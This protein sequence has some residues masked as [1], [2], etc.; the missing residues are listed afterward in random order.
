MGTFKKF[1]RETQ[2]WEV[3]STSDASVIGIRSEKLLPDGVSETNVEEV[4]MRM[5]DSIDTLK[6]NVSWLA[7]YG[8]S[9]GGS[10]SAL[11]GAITVNDQPTGTT[12][13]LDKSLVINIQASIAG[14][15]W[16]ISV[17]ANNKVI[18]SSIGTKLEL[19]KQDLLDAGLNTT[20]RLSISALNQDSMASLYWNGEIQITSIDLTTSNVNY[21]FQDRNSKVQLID[22]QVSV[23]G[24]YY[25]TINEEEVWRDN[26]VKNAG[27]I[28]IPLKILDE[29]GLLQVGNNTLQI[30]LHI[31]EEVYGETYAQVVLT[32]ETPIIVSNSLSETQINEIPINLGQINIIRMSYIVYYQAGN[33]KTKI[34]KKG[35]VTNFQD[36]YNSYNVLYDNASYALYSEEYGEQI[37][38]IIEIQDS[39]TQKSYYKEYNLVTVEPKQGLLSQ[40]LDSVFDFITYNGYINNGVWNQG[41][42]NLEIHNINYYSQSI[43]TDTK[44]LRLQNASYGTININKQ[45]LATSNVLEFTLL[46]CYEAD[47]H[48][49]DDRTILQFGNIGMDQQPINGIFVKAH[50][51][52]VGA[53]TVDLQDRE[54]INLAITYKQIPN[55]EWGQAFV[56]IDAVLEASFTVQAQMICPTQNNITIY[57][58]AQEQ[59]NAFTDVTIYRISL[60]KK[61]LNPYQLLLEFLNNQARTHLLTS[62]LP[63]ASYIDDGLLRNFIHRNEKGDLIPLL[64]NTSYN[65][66]VNADDFSDAFTLEN[67]IS[68]SDNSIEFRSDISNYRIPIP[69]M[70]LD[71]SSAWSWNNFITP[72]AEL[73]PLGGCALRYYDQ[74]Q[75]SSKIIQAS[76]DVSLQ[77][78]STLA[79]Y[80]KNIN[81]SFDDNCVF[82]PKPHWLPEKTYTL[83]ADIVDSSHSLNPSIGKFVNDEFGMAYDENGQVSSASSWYPF[84]ESV[85]DS[86][87]QAKQT[88]YMQDYFPQATLKHGVEGYPIFLIMRFQNGVDSKGKPLYKIA[89]LGIYQFILG[90]NSSRNLGYDIIDSVKGMDVNP[91]YPYFKAGVDIV[92][93]QNPGYWIEAVQNDSFSDTLGFQELNSIQDAQLTGVFWQKDITYLNNSF[94]I[95]FTNLGSNAVSKPADFNEFMNFVDSIIKLPVTNRRYSQEGNNIL[96]RNTFTNQTYPKYELQQING[97][98]KWIKTNQVNTIV[99]RGDELNSVLQKLNIESISRFYV[100]AMLLGLLDNFQKNM[101]IKFFRKS[102]GSWENAILG[103][104]DTDSG[105]GG[106]NEGELTIPESLWMCIFK[107]FDQQVT[108]S[109]GGANQ[110]VIGNSNK[111]WYLDSSDLNYS[112]PTPVSEHCSIFANAWQ[113]MIRQLKVNSLEELVDIFM[114]KYF[115]PQ[116][117]SCGELVFNL[118]YFSKYI[119]KYQTGSQLTNQQNKFHGRRKYQIRRWLYNRVRFLD[120]IF[121]AMGTQEAISIVPNSVAIDSGKTNEFALTTNYATILK[122]DHQGNTPRFIFC[123][124]NEQVNVYWGSREPDSQTVTHTINYPESIQKLGNEQCSLAD[125]NY[126]KINSGSLPNLT[127]FDISNCLQLGAMNSDGM[128]KF[129]SNGK[130]ELRIINCSNTYSGNN[131]FIINIQSGFTK[132]QELN[133]NNSCV[134]QLYLPINPNIPL[135][136]MN[137]VGAK[138]TSLTLDSQNLLSELDITNCNKLMDL[139]ITNCDKLTTLNLNDTQLELKNVIIGSDSFKE[140]NCTNNPSVTTIQITSNNLSKVIITGCSKLKELTVSGENLKHLNLQNCTSLSTLNIVGKVTELDY[141]NLSATKLKT[142]QYNGESTYG[143]DVSKFPNIKEFK[144]QSNNVVEYIQFRNDAQNPFV[145]TNSFQGCSSLK[146]VYGNIAINCTSTFYG[147]KEFSI[148]GTDTTYYLGNYIMDGQRVKHPT[149]IP[150]I[151]END[152]MKFQEGMGVTNMTFVGTNSNSCFRQTKCTIFDIYYILYNIGSST[153]IQWAFAELQDKSTF[154]WNTSVDNSP[155]RN[156]FI[157][158]AN[159]T[160]VSNSFRSTWSSLR[161]FSPEHDDKVVLKNNGLLSPLINCTNMSAMFYM[162]TY[163]HIDR[164]VFQRNDA[165]LKIQNIS[166]WNNIYNLCNDISEV[167]YEEALV[168][169][170]DSGNFYKI[171]DGLPLISLNGFARNTPFINYNFLVDFRLIPNSV[172]HIMGVF[173]S[174]D[175]TGVVN[176][177]HLIGI[178][179]IKLN[180][181]FRSN[182]GD[183]VMYID[184]DTL[185]SFPKLEYISWET[186]GD[187][188]AI[189]SCSFQ[190]INKILNQQDFPY[191]ILRNCPNIKHFK[192]F[193][194]GL[195]S[196]NSSLQVSIPGSLFNESNKLTEIDYLF[197]DFGI[198]YELTSESFANCP[199]LSSASYTFAS[200]SDSNI[201][202]SIPKKLFYHGRKEVTKTWEYID[203]PDNFDPTQRIVD[204]DGNYV[205]DENGNY[206]YPIVNEQDVQTVSIKYYQYNTNLS[207]LEGCF[208]GCNSDAYENNNPE[209]ESNPDYFPG[210]YYRLNGMWYKKDKNLYLY[211]KAWEYDGTDQV[212]GQSYDDAH[213]LDASPI[214]TCYGI[215]RY[216]IPNYICSP[217]LLRYCSANVNINYL[218]AEQVRNTV[219]DQQAANTNAR[220]GIKGRIPPYLL[221]PVPNITSIEGMFMNCKQLSSYQVEDGSTYLI[222]KSFFTY[223]TKLTNLERA[224]EGLVFPSKVDLNVFTPL[225]NKYLQVAQIFQYPLFASGT[226]ISGVIFNNVLTLSKAFNVGTG[227]TVDGLNNGINRSQT[228]TFDRV[229]NR[230]TSGNDTY[231]FDGYSKNTVTFLNKVLRTDQGNNYRV[232]Q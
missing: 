148:L 176:L 192:G 116:T 142:I 122:I 159:V 156:T 130:S 112:L 110:Q 29:K 161:I 38:L 140:I 185:V 40:D 71:V 131:Q 165:P 214:T 32:A 184:D 216:S 20:F 111:L 104:Y 44:S 145:I 213:V 10:G 134:S 160:D 218:F 119:N 57:L 220:Y 189:G 26:I 174:Q 84:A 114:D 94:E 128:N 2:Q 96:L 175:S 170:N 66:N 118:T 83:K 230:Y 7:T 37:T 3:L 92:T 209:Q 105:C 225:S 70:L 30:K 12:I 53:N 34:Y 207:N 232:I 228:V 198:K 139:S 194:Q 80:I 223:S 1:N 75:N 76:V 123:P 36:K 43:Q 72:N 188:K 173:N 50:T 201:L 17:T 24:V 190:G 86:F 101:P 108:E 19:T 61:C 23:L 147:C 115:I 132:L 93:K 102:D 27:T 48:P 204:S 212:D 120:S 58:G 169:N 78:T 117:E 141:L 67:L 31:T 60:F 100:I 79:D 54:L 85:K 206:T 125:I 51:L 177:Q 74:T 18:K 143:L 203:A 205:L 222:P 95:K 64:W 195:T 98:Y 124:K 196:D 179:T 6:G 150:K 65:F 191:N 208:K 13:I 221:K 42:T 226:V 45:Q 5:K 193:F 172:T 107:N 28:E 109:S 52:Y 227:T 77:G 15:N 73:T 144:I 8:G 167:T 47:F 4:L 62:G 229:F 137:I 35:D 91:T 182:S 113:S 22:Y 21:P 178:N 186:S 138:L 56:Y 103:I 153:S 183:A 135:K 217:D 49:D 97:S 164:F 81:I 9:G 187:F 89:T 199:K 87:I 168:I 200:D 39:G 68:I 41:T 121:T 69:V 224:F 33:Y 166:Y 157:N 133:I 129:T 202:G 151:T 158:C 154:V 127:E 63:D 90:R 215:T 136:T 210:N 55:S 46:L 126:Q 162:T 16:E 88:K 14:L 171:F 99:N 11:T 180:T 59:E 219:H 152:K 211:T 106:D 82:I 149:E 231:V 181:S 25:L 146:R 197:K 163:I 155:H